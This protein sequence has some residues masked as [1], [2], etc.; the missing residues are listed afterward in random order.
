MLSLLKKIIPP[1]LLPLL[2]KVWRLKHRAGIFSKKIKGELITETQLITQLKQAGISQGDSLL[3]H[4]SLRKIG[5]VQ[6]GATTVIQ[7]LIKTLGTNGTLLMPAFPAKGYNK[8]Y[9]LHNT[10]FNYHNTQSSMGIITEVFRTQYATHRSLHATDSVCA[11]GAYADYITNTHLGQLT[12]YNEHSPFYKLCK[13]HGKILLLGVDL[14]SLTNFHTL[15]DAVEHFIYPVYDAQEFNVTLTDK[16]NAV[17]IATTKVH[18]PEY[19]AKRQ[20]L[21]FENVFINDGIMR[22]IKIGNATSYL[23]EAAKLQ[24]WMIINY[25]TKKITLYTPQGSPQ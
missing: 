7:A 2:R 11:L 25:Q 17:H 13:A 16:N 24:E 19:S 6:H 1:Q 9:L 18:N 22:K 10:M 14:N 21:A 5:Y 3:V 12:P 23:I 8:D 4:S 20:C 15:E